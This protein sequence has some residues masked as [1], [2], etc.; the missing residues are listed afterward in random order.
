[1]GNERSKLFFSA[2]FISDVI[3]EYIVLSKVVKHKKIEQRV[4]IKILTPKMFGILK[5]Y[6]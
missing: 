5:K 1:M 2:C 6:F 3:L 4:D